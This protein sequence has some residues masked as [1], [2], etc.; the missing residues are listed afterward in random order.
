MPRAK[1]DKGAKDKTQ[2]TS[3][4]RNDEAILVQTLKEQKLLGHFGDNN[5]K[6]GVWHEC[7]KALAGSEKRSGGAPKAFGAIKNRWQ[8]VH[9]IILGYMR[10]FHSISA[11]EGI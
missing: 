7:E 1:A 2:P 6:M 3:W 11:Q 9:F 5:P 4:H 8:R 10:I